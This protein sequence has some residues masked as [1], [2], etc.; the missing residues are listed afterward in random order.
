MCQSKVFQSALNLFSLP[1]FWSFN[2]CKQY[3]V[4]KILSDHDQAS[5]IFSP[6]SHYT[7]LSLFNP[8]RHWTILKS[9]HTLASVYFS[10]SHKKMKKNSYSRDKLFSTENWY[11]HRNFCCQKNDSP[12]L[13]IS[14]TYHQTSLSSLPPAFPTFLN[15]SSIELL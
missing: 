12:T 1:K 13:Q 5:T 4:Q 10:V 7:P 9:T 3:L 14:S 15:V 2:V 6:V 11:A 8:H